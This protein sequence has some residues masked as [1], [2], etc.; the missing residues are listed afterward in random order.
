MKRAAV[1][2]AGIVGAST[3]LE[4]ARR[5]WKVVVFDREK[6][7]GLGSTA[8]SSSVIRCHYTLPEAIMLA[9][10]GR[11]VWQDWAGHTGLSSPRARY[12]RTGVLFLLRENEKAGIQPHGLGVKAEVSGQDISGRFMWMN[13]LGVETHLVR[14]PRL[15]KQFPFLKVDRDEPVVGLYEPDSGYV[16]Y[17]RE[18]MED[19]GEACGR[20]GV[21][22]RFGEEVRT[23]TTVWDGPRRR[24]RAVN[25]VKVDAAVNCAGPDSARVNLL[26]NCPIGLNTQPLRQ[27][28]LEGVWSN[29]PLLKVPA[30]ADLVH[31]YYVRPDPR[32]FKIGAVRPRDHCDFVERHDPRRAKEIER[33]LLAGM[34]RR[35]PHIRVDRVKTRLAY[36]DWTVADSTPI[37]D[38]TDVEG[39]FVTIGSSGAWFKS[40]PVF[41]H[42]MAE[43][44]DA[45]RPID[46]VKLPRSGHKIDLKAF[47]RSRA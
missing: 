7:A 30:I 43:I 41:G 8:R 5:G 16:A 46:V 44:V 15:E 25:G 13:R 11:M 39:F 45:G 12:C 47:A 22:F 34:R 14:G 19:L 24:V 40:G 10:E 42:V 6:G 4:L 18:V 3:A 2:G 32:V 29:P 1:I 27:Y 28:V 33:E 37:L 21:R 17:P 26:A 9:L 20:E 38:R 23:I 31:G 35:L 36:Y